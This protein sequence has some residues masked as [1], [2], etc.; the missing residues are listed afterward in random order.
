MVRPPSRRRSACPVDRQRADQLGAHLMRQPAS[1]SHVVPVIGGEGRLPGHVVVRDVETARSP[2][3]KG[4][5]GRSSF[6]ST[7]TSPSP[8]LVW[9]LMELGF[10][11]TNAALDCP[12][13][14]AAQDRPAVNHLPCL[15]ELLNGTSYTVTVGFRGS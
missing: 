14:D 4:C 13:S 10:T 8:N 11:S 12:P 6:L 3:K 2:A 1:P 7:Y 9:G 15:L 5:G